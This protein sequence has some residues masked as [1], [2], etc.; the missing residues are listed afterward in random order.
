MRLFRTI[1][2]SVTPLFLTV[3]PAH[4]FPAPDTGATIPH[5]QESRFKDRSQP[6]DMT[7]G[8]QMAKSLGFRDGRWEVFDPGS[9]QFLMPSV[10]GGIDS[11]GPMLRL[12]WRQ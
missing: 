1:L 11:G 3:V 9:G 12:Q 5:V 7:Y 10:K 4:A 8:D 6:Y 2:W